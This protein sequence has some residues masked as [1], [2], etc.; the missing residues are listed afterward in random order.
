M[1]RPNTIYWE[2]QRATLRHRRCGMA[3][4]F[5]LIIL[6]V[7]STAM[8]TL[9]SHIATHKHRQQ[10]LIDYQNA[11]Y[12]CDSGMKYA[13]AAMGNLK[14][15]LAE[16]TDQPDFSDL[17]YM[18]QE[19]Y[20]QYLSDWA[21]VLAERELMEGDTSYPGRN[22]SFDTS[23]L[24]AAGNALSSLFSG[25]TGGDDPNTLFGMSGFGNDNGVASFG[26]I[27]DPNEIEIPGPYGVPWPFVTEP[28]EVQIGQA[29]VRIEIADENA[30]MPLTWVLTS[31]DKVKRAVRDATVLF[32]EWMQ[33]DP[34]EID[35][36]LTRLDQIGR[37][38]NFTI[39]P[40]PVTVTQQVESK[41]I[42][43][44]TISRS[45][46][47]RTSTQ[48]LT[49]R[50]TTSIR[51]ARPAIMNTADFARLLHSSSLDMERLAR[52][53]PD[54]GKRYESAL[55]YLALWGSQRININTAPR[56]VLEAAFTFG[57]HHVEIADEIIRQRREKP[58]KSI[59]D[60]KQSLK[61]YATAIRECEPYIATESTFFSITI[62]AWSGSATASAVATVVKEGGQVQTIAML[63]RR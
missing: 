5:V 55:K 62:T 41:A 19:D 15:K 20:E 56:H 48:P 51:Q 47:L 21:V 33:L 16:R 40:K 11:R 26:R 27:S 43:S 36:M 53:I 59:E 14:C 34:E 60:L 22:S 8:Y 23:G 18:T 39:D 9:S 28:I 12:A 63:T 46:R 29:K 1:T 2:P 49:Q 24:G 61:G 54:T 52:P 25:F 31:D 4:V 38:K 17:F 57:G 10:F 44:R 58:Y 35:D 37:I 7:L 42:T 45:S 13:L 30:K 50:G 6:V 32:F 3:L